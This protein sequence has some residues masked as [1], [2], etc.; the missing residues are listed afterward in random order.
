MKAPNFP[1]TLEE[2]A[3]LLPVVIVVI[4]SAPLLPMMLRQSLV[5]SSTGLS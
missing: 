1:E 2:D 4:V 5:S 3:L